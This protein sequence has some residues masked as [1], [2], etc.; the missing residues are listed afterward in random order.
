MS[1]AS[2]IPIEIWISAGLGLLGVIL[3]AL[4]GMVAKIW[5][6]TQAIHV[7]V[8]SNLAKVRLDLRWALAVIVGIAV[9]AIG[10]LVKGQMDGAK[11]ERDRK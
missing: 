2:D 3:A 6:G 9:L 5:Q 4:I 7:L 10:A 8:N 11:R 1:P